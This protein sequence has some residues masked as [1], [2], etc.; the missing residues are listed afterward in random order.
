MIVR[1]AVSLRVLTAGALALAPIA[2]IAG[3]VKPAEGDVQRPG[4][5]SRDSSDLFAAP[6]GR[7]ARFPSPD[8][9]LVVVM[10]QGSLLVQ[11][12]GKT[13]ATATQSAPAEILW[14][15]DSSSFAV[16]WNDGGEEGTWHVTVHR[17]GDR[18]LE[19]VDASQAVVAAFLPLQRCKEPEFPDAGAV[20]WLDG[21][22][23]L[24]VVARA[25]TARN[26]PSEGLLQGYEVAP[27]TGSIQ[28]TI[29]APDLLERYRSSFGRGVM[30]R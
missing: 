14:S 29:P 11:S 20:A 25:S 24:L 10:E 15:P 7:P 13:V 19:S 18:G 26:C 23:S 30:S 5:W 22:K 27:G 28:K 16:T 21:G 12:D 6:P 4:L 9:N 2:A 17:L 3:V 1:L 8:G